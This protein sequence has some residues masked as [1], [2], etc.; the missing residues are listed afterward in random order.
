MFA[1]CPATVERCRIRSDPEPLEARFKCLTCQC[2]RRAASI[3]PAGHDRAVDHD[4][5]IGALFLQEGRRSPRLE[6]RRARSV[7]WRYSPSKRQLLQPSG[8]PFTLHNP[9][10]SRTRMAQQPVADEATNRYFQGDQ[11]TH[12]AT[13]HDSTSRGKRP[14][15]HRKPRHVLLTAYTNPN[16][17]SV[18]A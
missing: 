8:A 6:Q 12:S 16:R 7:H 13:C 17:L 1:C 4:Q 9:R 14:W 5:F 15:V 11:A 2:R 3:R 18:L 10:A